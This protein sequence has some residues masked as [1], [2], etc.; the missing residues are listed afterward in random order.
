[1]SPADPKGAQLLVVDDDRLV[2]ANLVEGLEQAG[3]VVL[4]ATSG[5]EAV[6]ICTD[7]SPDLVVMDVCMPTM[8]GIEAARV[9]REQ[10]GLPAFFLSAFDSEDMVKEAVDQGA[11]G[12]LVK[13]VRINQ[14][15]TS[16]EAALAR[17]AE[18]KALRSAEENLQIALRGD[19][20]IGIATG[21]MM[22]RFHMTA[23]DAFETLRKRARAERRKLSEVA[24]EIVGAAEKL[25]SPRL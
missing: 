25:S 18:I 16:I 4:K 2:L 7:Q 17:A 8:S 3:Y 5:E 20:N 1:M 15:V 19:R 23:I 11:L 13:P 12:Y 22:E 6:Q 9:I 14:L 10:S 24:A 21:L